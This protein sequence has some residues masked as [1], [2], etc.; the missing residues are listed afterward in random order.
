MRRLRPLAR[1]LRRWAGRNRPAILL[2][3]RVARIAHDPWALAVPPD[4]FAEQ[5]EALSRTRRVVPLARLAEELE[6]GRARA[7]WIAIT[8]D[9]GYADLLHE[10]VP[11]MQRFGCPA[12][13][14]VTTGAL[15]GAGFWWDRLSEAVFRP[16]RLA[17]ALALGAGPDRFTWEPSAGADRQ[18]LHMALWRRLRG[19]RAGDREAELAA[20]E[21]WAGIA[22]DRV[23]DRV[24]SAEEVRG[25]ARSGFFSIGAHSVSHAPLPELNR[26]EKA[27]EI[28][29]SRRACEEILGQP[30]LGFAYPFGD[31]DA[32]SREEVRRAGFRFACS[33]MP[34]PVRADSPRYA[35][36]R[37]SVGAWSGDE[38]LRRL[39]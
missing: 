27:A 21:R 16:E 20:I 5:M 9:D 18:Q 30:V 4:L 38:L 33:T 10:A 29:G 1:K 28:A 36:P 37:L 13:M 32:E 15:G 12:T 8:F 6:R 2:Y 19:L 34:E 39:P 7:N 31:L 24:M 23:R 25:L 35:L 22:P 14:F 11:A 3:H 26:F 17:D